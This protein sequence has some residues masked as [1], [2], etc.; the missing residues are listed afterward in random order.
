MKI[1]SPQHGSI[2]LVPISPDDI[3]GPLL[4][5]SNI[6]FCEKDFGTIM[7]QQ[8]HAE[9]YSLRYSIFNFIKKVS[10]L[11][12]EEKSLLRTLLV[13]K[14]SFGIKTQ[15]KSKTKLRE[16][17]FLLF[18]SGENQMETHFANGNE[19]Q[20]FDATYSESL[21]H[22]LFEN[23]PSLKE[24]LVSGNAKN[25]PPSFQKPFLS[26]HEMTKI[27][28]DLLRCPYDENLRKIYF[29]NKVNDF[30]FEVLVQTFKAKPTTGNLNQKEN[31]AVFNAR[32]IIL[33]DLAK[34]NSI[35]EISQM[36]QLNEF[37]LKTGF[38]QIFGTGIFEFLL[39][40]RMKKARQLLI[41]TDKPIK[42]IA[43]LAGYG[44]LTNFITA[45]KNHFGH[46]PRELRKNHF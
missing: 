45:F 42:E 46:T 21:L 1:S 15:S 41:E 7:I 38:K 8:Y 29:E 13:Q 23:F 40:A 9:N 5:G 28:N 39:Q 20:I 19:Y 25:I 14:G 24:Y 44:H 33:A 26:S 17:Q 35:R 2:D 43:A 4:P 37:K 10:L 32:D 11:F 31:S 27:V 16:S 36:V 18:N 34:H 6:L 3:S 22:Q 12:S 30:L